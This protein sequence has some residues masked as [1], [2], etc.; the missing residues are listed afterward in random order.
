MKFLMIAENKIE[1]SEAGV[2]LQALRRIS[3]ANTGLALI[4]LNPK[5]ENSIII[6]GGANIFYKSLDVLPEEYQKAIRECKLQ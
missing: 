1:M 5:R 3:E 2:Q 4:F 6:I